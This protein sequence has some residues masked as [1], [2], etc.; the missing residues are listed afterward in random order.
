MTLHLGVK[1]ILGCEVKQKIFLLMSS[2]KK[3]GRH[4]AV[5]ELMDKRTS[6]RHLTLN[7]STVLGLQQTAYHLHVQ[8]LSGKD[9]SRLWRS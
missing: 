3:V 4:K 6:E 2:V 1:W 9:K 5:L 8:L 7:G